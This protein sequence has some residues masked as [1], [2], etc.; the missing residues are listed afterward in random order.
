[1]P[2]LYLIDGS[3]LV[4]RTHFAFSRVGLTGPNGQPLGATYGVALFLHSIQNRSDLDAVACVFDTKEPTFRHQLYREYKATREKMPSELADQLDG[5]KQMTAA[6]GFE[7]LEQVGYE[8]DD[9]IG[10]LAQKAAD[11]NYDVFI[12]SGDKDFGQ[13]VSDRIKLLVPDRQGSGLTIMDASAVQE[14]WGVPPEKIIDYMGLKGDSSDN[15]PGVPKVG[16]KTAAQLINQFGSLEEVLARAEEVTKPALKNNLI[17]FADQARLSQKLV[18]ID[19]NVPVEVDFAELVRQQPDKEKLLDFY[20]T[21]GFTSLIDRLDL[22][23]SAEPEKLDYKTITSEKDLEELLKNLKNSDLVSFDLESTSQYPMAAELVGFSFAIQDAEAFYV[24]V[25]GGFFPEEEKGF[26]RLGELVFGETQWLLDKLRPIL[27]DE[28]IPKCG[29]NLKYDALV[30]RC[31]GV[32]VKGIVFDSMI[33]SYLIDPSRRQ[34]NIDSLSLEYLNF[35]K[36]PTSELIGSG[37][38]QISMAEVPVEKVSP[39][40]CEDADIARRLCLLLKEK[41]DEQKLTSLFD[42][43]E[44]PLLYV[45]LEMEYKGVALDRRMLKTMSDDM[46]RQMQD[47][48]DQIYDL[49]GA[50]FNINSTK[51]L[52]EILFDKLGLKPVKKTKTGYSTDVEVLERLAHEHPLPEKLLEY[53][54]YQKLK[55]TYLDALPQMINPV[56][57]RVHTSFNQT[58]AATGRLSSSDPNLQNIPIRTELGGQIRKAFIPGNSSQVLLSAD[59]SQIELRLVAHISG[60]QE[61]ISAFKSGEDIHTATAAKIMGVAPEEVTPE[62]RRS[63][64]AINFGIIYGMGDW[65]LSERLGIPLNVAA[66]FRKQYFATYPGVRAYMD[67]TIEK[68]HKDKKVT[69]MMGRIRHLPDID[70]KNK[71]VREFAERT[72][73]NTPIQGTAADMIKLAMLQI[74]KR[75]NDEKLPAKMILQVHDELVFEVDRD[76]LDAVKTA[77]REEME[78]AMQLSVPVI[79]DMGIGEN[80]LEAH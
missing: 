59:Y 49:A 39:Y 35:K 25:N 77:V 17:E 75:I 69:T 23:Q 1:M 19:T 47:L 20:K 34:H 52:Q 56:T 63:A 5:I 73:I 48:T 11:D 46:G 38:K 30:L 7:V 32:H 66:D 13:L 79:V 53:R 67:D 65:G 18:T 4:Y 62:M 31:Y 78:N 80:W 9:I 36:I 58:V 10:T 76:S 43:L 71:N 40:A 44:L 15:I 29:Q 33:A 12:L 54:Q 2:T 26:T 60:D 28:N 8:A 24:P 57:G 21:F 70:A 42:D 3:A 50:E 72:A 55:S 51:Q 16:D 14:K 6:F 27:E 41:L 37:Q 61:L 74:Q 64:K 22:E 45:L 68:A